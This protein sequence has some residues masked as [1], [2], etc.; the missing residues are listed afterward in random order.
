MKDRVAQAWVLP[1]CFLIVQWLAASS[2]SGIESFCHLIETV[3]F[4]CLWVWHTETFIFNRLR[5]MATEGQLKR[6]LLNKLRVNLIYLKMYKYMISS[7]ICIVNKLLQDFLPGVCRM[8][9]IICFYL[10]NS[11]RKVN[12][13]DWVSSL[14][15]MSLT[16][17][18]AVLNFSWYTRR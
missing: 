12:L 2:Y 11:F 4:T 13:N 8:C 3:G 6:C 18:F 16:Y 10:M 5:G 14:T 17:T 1:M 9:T 15:S 7:I